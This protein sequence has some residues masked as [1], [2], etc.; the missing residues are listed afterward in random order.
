MKYLFNL[1]KNLLPKI[2]ETELIALRSGTTSLDRD[3]MSG[4]V[5]KN[6]FHL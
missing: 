2:S 4:I 6:L 5:N 3:I 1:A